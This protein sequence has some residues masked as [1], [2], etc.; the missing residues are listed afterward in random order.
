[1]PRLGQ[2]HAPR[3]PP[4]TMTTRRQWCQSTVQAVSQQVALSW[5]PTSPHTPTQKGECTTQG[6]KIPVCTRMCN[7]RP[8]PVG[9]T[10]H[11]MRA[12][13]PFVGHTRHPH[14]TLLPTTLPAHAHTRARAK[15]QNMAVATHGRDK[16]EPAAARAHPIQGPV[17]ARPATRTAPE[18]CNILRWNT[19]AARGKSNTRLRWWA[20]L[21]WIAKSKMPARHIHATCGPHRMRLCIVLNSC[22]AAAHNKKTPR[23]QTIM[24]LSLMQP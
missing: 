12:G 24:P 5:A 2:H 15:M 10:P 20:P 16:V 7:I 17:D 18:L 23:A 1:V 22:R 6:G 21:Q 11:S 19:A 13:T 4:P 8:L 3:T 14:P 9:C